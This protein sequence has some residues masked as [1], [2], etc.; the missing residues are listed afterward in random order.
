MW[1]LH[2]T[3]IQFKLKVKKE[4]KRNYMKTNPMLMVRSSMLTRKKY[5]VIPQRKKR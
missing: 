2:T 4:L 1:Y 3:S 5:N